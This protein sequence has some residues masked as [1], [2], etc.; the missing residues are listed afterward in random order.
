MSDTEFTKGEWIAIDG[1]KVGEQVLFVHAV[2]GESSKGIV[3][4]LTKQVNTH[5][6]LSTEDIA[7]SHLIAA[8][9]KMYAEL[10]DILMFELDGGSAF[11]ANRI[12]RLLAEARGE[13]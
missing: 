12:A 7:N 5:I 13:I 8:A 2:D 9:P 6:S 11:R 1:T 3:C 10:E 4:R